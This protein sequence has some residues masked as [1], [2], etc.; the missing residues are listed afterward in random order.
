LF[1]TH[2]RAPPV[3]YKT[4]TFSARDVA[5][6]TSQPMTMRFHTRRAAAAARRRL[7]LALALTALLPAVLLLLSAL[8]ASSRRALPTSL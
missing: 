8:F 2:P 4:N 7:A 5:L 1:R 3:F 6:A